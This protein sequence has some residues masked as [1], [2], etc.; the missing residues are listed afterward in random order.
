MQL[1][2]SNTAGHPIVLR[3]LASSTPSAT[4][5]HFTLRFRRGVL[6]AAA[7]ALQLVDSDGWKASAPQT[8]VDRVEIYLLHA[9]S[10]PW[11]LAPA[12]PRC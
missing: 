8:L 11:P 10:A 6:S 7:D 3:P 4:N 5:C 12:K 9:H 1:A 2:I